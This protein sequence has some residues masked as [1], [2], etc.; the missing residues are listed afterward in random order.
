[1][2]LALLLLGSVALMVSGCPAAPNEPPPPTRQPE[3]P[4]AP[5]RALGALAAGT[6]AAPRPDVTLPGAEAEPEGA[7][8]PSEA[9]VPEGSAPGPDKPVPAPALAPDAGMAL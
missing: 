3:I 7:P 4:A 2:R 8:T 9:P 5:P 1:M 6:D